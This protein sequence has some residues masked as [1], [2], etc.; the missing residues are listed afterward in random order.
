MRPGGRLV[1][2]FGGAGNVRMLYE[3]FNAALHEHGQPAPERFPWY[4]P[5]ARAYSALLEA[6]GFQVL[7]AQLFER[8]T[9]LEGEDGLR[10]WYA[11]F[12]GEQL[13]RLDAAGRERV[14]DACERR[15]RPTQWRDG[16]WI[17]DYVRLRVVARLRQGP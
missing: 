5:T 10:N 14:L 9:P 15:L 6:Q 12:L 11:M 13:E 4:F 16:H 2:E 1:A 3:A 17:A 7:A 8:P